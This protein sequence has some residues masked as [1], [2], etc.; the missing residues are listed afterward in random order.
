MMAKIHAFEKK[1]VYISQRTLVFVDTA[2]LWG[3]DTKILNVF[4]QVYYILKF[5]ETSFW[6]ES[7]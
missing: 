6:D 7:I 1:I 3:Q 4:L 2:I 5:L